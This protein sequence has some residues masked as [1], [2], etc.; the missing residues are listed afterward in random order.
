MMSS[1]SFLED[2]LWEKKNIKCICNKYVYNFVEENDNVNRLNTILYGNC[3][4]ITRLIARKHFLKDKK[5]NCNKVGEEPFYNNQDFLEFKEIDTKTFIDT[6]QTLCMTKTIL[7]KKQN[8]IIHDLP[9]SIQIPTFKII[10]KYIHNVYVILTFKSLNNIC[11]NIKGGFTLINCNYKYDKKIVKEMYDF[12]S[13]SEDRHFKEKNYVN[14]AFSLKFNEK[15]NDVQNSINDFVTSSLK[16]ILKNTKIDKHFLN[17]KELAYK[18]TAANIPFS[19]ISNIIL[20]YMI[21]NKYDNTK[22]WEFIE[23]SSSVDYKLSL[24]NKV[25][26][27]YEYFFQQVS[28]L[29]STKI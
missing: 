5:Y 3:R 12:L 22:I 17:I 29:L 25:V 1:I 27:S 24:S 19:M 21:R 11:Q 15:E 28:K 18:C 20:Q 10:E 13:I 7:N 4:F 8:I 23:L 16:S 6:F 26:F 2:V 9:L 14:I